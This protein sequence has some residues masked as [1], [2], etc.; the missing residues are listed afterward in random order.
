MTITETLFGGLLLVALIFFA[1][2]RLGLSTYWSGILGGALP[3]L[4]YLGY[5]GG[6]RQ[7]GDVLAIHLVVFMATAG[8]LAVFSSIRQKQEKMHW[9]P[10]AIIAFF[11]LLVIFNAVLLSI[12]T[13]GLPDGIAGWFLPNR[14][15]QTVHTA[16][17]G[18][19]PHDRNKLYEMHQQ[20]VAEQRDLG[21]QV[22]VHGL[23]RL[24]SGTASALKLTVRDAHG[25][26][27]VADR[28]TLGFWRMANSQDD[29]K[30][31]LIPG[32]AG[33]YRAEIMLP[34]PGRWIAEI[35]IERGR[36]SYQTQ[37]PLLVGAR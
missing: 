16:F 6:E 20:R 7:G 17:P 36:D 32:A 14:D 18:I 37:R 19:V 30:L 29:R 34:D 8:V 11:V 35:R 9:A 10:K 22:E 12:A 21:W 1:G 5:S 24:K 13:H 33:E 25:Q 2:R 3:F 4:A 26:P 15:K 23:D 27:L 31:E 28:A